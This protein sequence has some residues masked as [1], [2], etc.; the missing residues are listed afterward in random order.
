M[1]STVWRGDLVQ[2]SSLRDEEV[3]VHETRLDA[4]WASSPAGGFSA[5]AHVNLSLSLSLFSL[6]LT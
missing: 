2:S 1:F 5:T 3:Q 4:G 6:Q